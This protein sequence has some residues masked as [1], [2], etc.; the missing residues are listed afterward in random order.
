MARPYQQAASDL[1]SA[2][3]LVGEAVDAL[4][5]ALYRMQTLSQATWEHDDAFSAVN[6]TWARVA[7]LH[8]DIKARW[9]T[10]ANRKGQE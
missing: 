9:I 10:E 7:E 6:E 8:E 1:D 5:R 3:R 4:R 2:Q